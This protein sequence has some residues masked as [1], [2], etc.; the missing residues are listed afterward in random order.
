M[1]RKTNEALQ[2]Y[3]FKQRGKSC[4]LAGYEEIH[5][6]DINLLRK[7]TSDGGRILPSRITYV[8]ASKQ[9]KLKRAIKIARALALLP[10]V[11]G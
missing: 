6:S 5:F 9:R 3:P 11:A 8:S 7:F 2:N 1:K 10:Y 4:P